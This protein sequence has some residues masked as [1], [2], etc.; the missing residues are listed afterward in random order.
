MDLIIWLPSVIIFLIGLLGWKYPCFINIFPKEDK[1]KM[2]LPA[3]GKLFRN[4]F[5]A[6]AVLYTFTAYFLQ[7]A[8]MPFLSGIA[9]FFSILIAA[10]IFAAR[11]EKYKN[12]I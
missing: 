7:K 8:G 10:F 9:L 4:I 6:T 12:K 2:D 1:A 5:L 3:V 11:A